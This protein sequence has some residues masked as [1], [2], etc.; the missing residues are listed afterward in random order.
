MTETKFRAWH[1]EEKQMFE[2][3]GL[4]FSARQ[5]ELPIELDFLP[6]EFDEVHL[7]RFTGL[8]DKNKKKIFEGDVI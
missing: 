8:K 4:N 1:I 2:V 7:M 6:L 5:V 3:A